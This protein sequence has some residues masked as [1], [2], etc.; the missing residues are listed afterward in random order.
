[1]THW[2]MLGRIALFNI[3]DGLVA[4]NPVPAT[5]LSVEQ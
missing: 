4:L 5:Y 3:G 1:M 2:A